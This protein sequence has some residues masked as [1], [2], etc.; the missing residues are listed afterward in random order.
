MSGFQRVRN[1]A[2]AIFM[3]AAAIGLFVDPRT[4]Y[5]LLITFLGLGLMFYGIGKLIYFVTM[6]RHMVGGKIELYK[7]VILTEFG[8]LAYS[9]NDIPRVYVI[10][11]L[12]V[13]HLFQ[14]LVEVLRAMEAKGQGSHWR[15]KFAHGIVDFIIS[16]MCIVFIRKTN[17]A[18]FIYAWGLIYSA[19]MRIAASIRKNVV[20][21]DDSPIT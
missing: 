15:L 16:L 13:L 2:L 21:Y 3:L 14:G 4:G 20:V 1:I 18:V 12:A 6:A 9:A 7:G 8:Y 17:T 5:V 19:I 10:I 11:Y